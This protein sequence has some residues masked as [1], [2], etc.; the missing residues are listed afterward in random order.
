MF[1]RLF[2]FY[3]FIF[4]LLQIKE[5]KDKDITLIYKKW[6]TLNSDPKESSHSILKHKHILHKRAKQNALISAH[7]VYSESIY[8]IHIHFGH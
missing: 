8:F 1:F 6:N 2:S 7:I 4:F 5:L 3:I